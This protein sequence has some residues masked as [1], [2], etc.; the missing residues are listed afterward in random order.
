MGQALAAG[1]TA[2]ELDVHATADGHLVC[3][4]DP[5]VDRTTNGTGCIA[6]MTL[7]EVKALDNAW[8]FV[9]GLEV[10][11]GRPDAEYPF[12]GRAPADPAYAI[13][14][15]EEVLEAFPGVLLNLDIKRTAPAV[16]PYEVALAKL[17]ADHDRTDDVI[18]V[19]FHDTALETFSAAAPWAH[20]AAGPQ[21]T[22]EF[23]GAV[24]ERQ[25][26]PRLRHQA[27]QVPVAFGGTRVV[28]ADFVAAAHEAGMAVHVWTVD[29]RAEMEALVALG[30]DGI[31]SDVPSL[32]VQ[33]LA[34]LGVAWSG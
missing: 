8:W 18:V 34:A 6:R 11:P 19:S 21:A 15:L 2:L 24:R 32:L 5:T 9:P 31:M 13:P 30:V 17:L 20:T 7:A 16:P 25:P 22:A 26:P 4:H 12:R 29:D 23:W 14:T 27:L 33:V 3:C 1:A 28:D 10:A